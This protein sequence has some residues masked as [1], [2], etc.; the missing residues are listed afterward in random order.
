MVKCSANLRALRGYFSFFASLRFL[1]YNA[2]VWGLC[3]R[4]STHAKATAIDHRIHQN[5]YFSCRNVQD[6]NRA[7]NQHTS[8]S[9]V[10][11]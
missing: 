7:T 2:K 9:Y 5:Q 6:R 4:F 11:G 8:G 3:P 10:L 1:R